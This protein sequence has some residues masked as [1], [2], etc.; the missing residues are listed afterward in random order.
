MVTDSSYIQ[1]LKTKHIFTASIL[2]ITIEIMERYPELSEF[3]NEMP[4]TFLNETYPQIN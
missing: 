2:E 4:I 3:L 1:P